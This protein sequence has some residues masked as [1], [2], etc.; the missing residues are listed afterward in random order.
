MKTTD[1]ARGRWREILPAFGIDAKFLD[2]RKHH[3]C[4]CN[5]EGDDR[6]RF[7]DQNGSGSYFCACSAGDKGGFGLLECKTGQTFRELAADVDAMIGNTHE[8]ETRAPS[9]AEQLRAI[10]K[11]SPRSAYLAS[12]G[13]EVAPGLL[14]ATRVD[15]R[16]EDG[17][18]VG[19]YPA[20]L[21]PIT[22][23]GQFQ[24]FH[25]TYLERGKKAP[26][27][28][29][30]KV[31]PGGSIT[32]GA[33]E[34]YPAADIMGVAEGIETAIAARMIFDCPTHAAIS[35][36]CMAKWDAPDIAREVHI[37]ADNDQ[38]FAGTAA[39]WALAHRLK[40]RG[41]EPI[42]HIPPNVGQDWNDVLLAQQEAA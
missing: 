39:A 9:Y 30:R 12:R 23:K 15:Y 31:L 28:T 13:L 2:G 7:A 25:V 41:I 10:A 34:L 20:M 14:W 3:P 6:F 11:P 22:R 16:D 4:P 8:A 36:T 5:G 1:A 33:V 27:P 38:N 29:P 35:A 24:S 37:F 19:Q 26:V 40:M 32:G 18:V 42:V 17:N 21:A